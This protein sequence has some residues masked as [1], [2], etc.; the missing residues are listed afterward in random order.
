MKKL[1]L[2]IASLLSQNIVAKPIVVA[3]RGSSAY[4]PEHTLAAKAL[5]YG[6]GADYIE[7]D[8][9]LT[10]DGIPVVLH[11]I[12]LDTVTN[13]AT[14]FAHRKRK[15]GRYYAIDFS[16]AEIKTLRVTER[17]DRKTGSAVYEKRFPMWKSSFSV[18]TLAEEIELIQG[19]NKS[20]GRNVGL[21]LEIKSPA[22]HSKAGKDV[23][24]TVMTLLKKFGYPSTSKKIFLQCFDANTLKR[25]KSEFKTKI[26]LVQLVGENSWGESETDYDK[27]KTKAG[28]KEVSKYAQGLGPWFGQ[29]YLG[30][31]ENGNPKASKIVEWAHANNLQVH[32]YTFRADQL[33]PNMKAK[34]VLDFLFKQLKVDGVFSDFP[35]L[36]L[37][38][39]ESI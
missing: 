39:I 23:T 22:W 10:K 12:H 35:D 30:N 4:L 3:H 32:P 25:L 9:V 1:V 36:A 29:L 38:Y 21:Y 24:K 15:D 19:L 14:K 18:S 33:P 37:K 31:D 2:I 7:Q 5:A 6:M 28:I 26:P 17:F 11:D 8:V 34:Q 13:V 20:T 27:M 16:L